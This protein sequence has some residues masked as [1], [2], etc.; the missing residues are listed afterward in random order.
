MTRYCLPG[1]RACLRD[2]PR[3]K[4]SENENANTA[5]RICVFHGKNFHWEEEVPRTGCIAI[6]PQLRQRREGLLK[7]KL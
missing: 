3:E 7:R 1:L 5:A 4:E 2:E 6:M